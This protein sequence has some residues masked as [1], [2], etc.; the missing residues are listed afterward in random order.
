MRQKTKNRH[1]GF[2]LQVLL[3]ISAIAHARDARWRGKHGM[4]GAAIIRFY[5]N[6]RWGRKLQMSWPF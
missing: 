4:G 3:L 2:G 1:G 6:R 5:P